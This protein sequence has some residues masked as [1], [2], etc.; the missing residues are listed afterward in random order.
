[1]FFAGNATEV[2]TEN[3]MGQIK[4]ESEVMKMPKFN[5]TACEK[6]GSIKR[7][8]EWV[9]PTTEEMQVIEDHQDVITIV[10]Q[11]CPSCLDGDSC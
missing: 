1:M 10:N 4:K 6:C 3:K 7:Y 8:K 11:T 9:M 2:S 5:L